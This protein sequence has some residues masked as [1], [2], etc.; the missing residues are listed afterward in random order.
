[1]NAIMHNENLKEQLSAFVDAEHEPQQFDLLLSALRSDENK[2]VWETYHEIGDI[3][4]SEDLSIALSPGFKEK[5]QARLATEATY[6]NTKRKKS[7]PFNHKIAYATAAMVA[8]IAVFVPKF[9]GND[10]A[11]VNA[12][13]FTGQFAATNNV[14]QAKSPLLVLTASQRQN[15]DQATN[16]K[17]GA[18]PQMLRDPLVDSYLAA[19]QRYS[20]SMYSAVEYETG[21]INQEA[22]K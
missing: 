2:K 5:M 4:N 20:K 8:L 13:Y 22:E 15:P 21:P 11:E 14:V 7:N 17:Q 9:A 6:I 10:G 16:Y 18:R 3:L 19:H 12:P 1:M